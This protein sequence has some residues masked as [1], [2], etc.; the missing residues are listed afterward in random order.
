M[1]RLDFNAIT[2]EESIFQKKTVEF[3][4]S[5]T[6]IFIFFDSI[7]FVLEKFSV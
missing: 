7:L 5:L 3:D 2:R 1:V 4:V 6:F